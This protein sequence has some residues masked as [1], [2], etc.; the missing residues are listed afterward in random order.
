MP[1]KIHS[2]GATWLGKHLQLWRRLGQ[3]SEAELDV[4]EIDTDTSKSNPT[5]C[6]GTYLMF[7][8]LKFNQ[9]QYNGSRKQPDFMLWPQNTPFP[10][11]TLE[12]GWS[13]TMASL[14]RDQNVLLAGGNG[15]IKVVILVKWF[16]RAN[17]RVAGTVEV[18]RR[19]SNGQPFKQGSVSIFP[20]P[21]AVPRPLV[22]RRDELFTQVLPARNPG[23][24]LELDVE[25]LR[26]IATRHLAGMNL[27]PA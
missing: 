27:Q 24:L 10:T 21:F 9:G 4:L 25:E 12:S 7:V 8:A 13:E 6:Y 19:D 17:R 14:I 16:E 20:R 11:A 22:I 5:R 18:W 3:L 2:T 26:S 1:V 23:D 15:H